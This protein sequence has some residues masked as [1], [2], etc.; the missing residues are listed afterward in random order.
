MNALLSIPKTCSTCYF[1]TKAKNGQTYCLLAPRR[2]LHSEY[3]LETDVA[4][5]SNKDCGKNQTYYM[6]RPMD[7]PIPLLHLSDTDD[8]L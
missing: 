6:Q 2:L 1:C 3:Y 7:K 5:F 4:R 8:D